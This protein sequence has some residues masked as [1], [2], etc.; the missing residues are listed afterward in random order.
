[1]QI[2][3]MRAVFGKLHGETLELHDGLNI[4][5]APNETGK[6]TWCAFLL[7]MLYGINSRERDKA[8]VIAD[9]NRYAPWNGTPM[10]GRLDLSS[11]GKNI[12]L[13]RSTK[14]PTAPMGDFQATYTGTNDSVA[15]LNSASCG[16]ILL[17]VSRDVYARSAFIHQHS[18]PVTQT[19][20]LERRI[21]SLISSGEESA[22]FSEVNELLKK[23]LNRRHHHKTGQIPTLEAELKHLLAQATEADALSAQILSLRQQEEQ[24][25][26][27]EN[28]L[29]QELD[30]YI[31]WKNQQQSHR[32]SETSIAADEALRHA[33]NLRRQLEADHIPENETIARLR[34]ALVN[35]STTHH[36][37][38]KARADRD[39]AMKDL[40][41]AEA[42]VNNSPFAGQTPDQV[43]REISEPPKC[44]VN[45][46][47]IILGVYCTA[48]II[49][50]A[51]YLL[52]PAFP[53]RLE[54][55]FIGLPLILISTFA[56]NLLVDKRR[57]KA[58]TAA[59][60][61]RFGTANQ[62]EIAAMADTYLKLAENRDAAQAELDKRS[63][64][65]D[66]LYNSIS[67]NEQAI[68]LEIRR[69]APLAFDVS[70]ADTLLRGCAIRRKELAV[71]EAAAREARLLHESAMQNSQEKA[72]NLPQPTRSEN[73]IAADL[74]QTLIALSACRESIQHLMGQLSAIGDVTQLHTAVEVTQ[75]QLDVLRAEYDALQLAI[76][77]MA[78]ANQ[79]LQ[80]RFAP[81]LGQ[82][83]AQ[84]FHQLT[85]GRYQN[86]VLDRTLHLSVEPEG[87]H[88]Y[89]D[90]SLL[91][92]GAVDQLYLA[93]RLAIC[94]AV[95]PAEKNAPIVLD[96]ALANFD[97]ERCISAL[98]LLKEK[99]Q[100]R[101]ILLFTCHSR[102]AAYFANDPD[103]TILRLTN[104]AEK[105]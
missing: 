17:G 95:L 81:A 1:M 13:T 60:I 19:P 39:S 70:A 83:T 46:I 18:L 89:R 102:E 8:G 43:R 88:L 74:N 71:A 72:N 100:H 55:L 65:A 63:S 68:L 32:L 86:V 16:E 61:K 85:N 57:K 7:S 99:A 28:T 91:S 56:S 42:A 22:T 69:F 15:E 66:T 101:Q 31:T 80:N 94:E 30:Q 76:D 21:A 37:L 34:G 2:H 20:E 58:Q 105:V 10:S 93:A 67:S 25:T 82:R 90:S 4:I 79:S 54:F 6:S 3:R 12:T 64:V 41:Q 44:R 50:A 87:D 48:A 24:L 92:S 103:V 36:N 14:R 52:I 78:S 96:D 29:R 97:D 104:D 75:Q 77:S 45:G 84:L 26:S 35:L 27:Q 62:S 51:L 11:N 40:L 38:E 59:L 33:D 47:P 49:A 5:Q 23:Q 53:N 9:K 98:R 73:D